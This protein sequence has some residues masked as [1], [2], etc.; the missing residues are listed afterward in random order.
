MSAEDQPWYEHSDAASA[1]A[2][3]NASVQ[4]LPAQAA[5]ANLMQLDS[6]DFD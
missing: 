1:S 6:E 5:D 4:V 3:N 2:R